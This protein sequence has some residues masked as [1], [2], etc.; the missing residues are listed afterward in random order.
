MK[1]LKLTFQNIMNIEKI[2]PENICFFGDSY[3]DYQ[4]ADYFKCNFIGISTSRD[5]LKNVNCEKTSDYK[6]IF[7]IFNL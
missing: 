1:I 5:D 3:S 4:V 2:K 6:T 7:N